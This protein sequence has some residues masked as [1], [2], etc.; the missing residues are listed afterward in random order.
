MFK[1]LLAICERWAI[2]D[3]EWTRR[4][5]SGHLHSVDWQKNEVAQIRVVEIEYG[6]K[7]AKEIFSVLLP[8]LRHLD[9]A[10]RRMVIPLLQWRNR[11]EAKL[12][13]GG[14]E[15]ANPGCYF[16]ILNLGSP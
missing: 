11:K 15:R 7:E 16:D 10:T 3:Q 5:L 9:S 12:I 6:E 13:S 8:N 4:L 1:C 14:R 2:G